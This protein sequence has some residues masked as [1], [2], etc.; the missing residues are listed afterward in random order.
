MSEMKNV[1]N[2]IENGVFRL[3]LW[4]KT[5]SVYFNIIKHKLS[6]TCIKESLL[7]QS[8]SGLIRQVTF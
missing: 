2:K 7:E 4:Y 1:G 8:K 5:M 6:Q 3:F